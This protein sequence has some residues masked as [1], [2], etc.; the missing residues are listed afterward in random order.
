MPSDNCTG[1]FDIFDHN[2]KSVVGPENIN[3][4]QKLTMKDRY[5]TYYEIK[6]TFGIS[7]TSINKILYGHL[8]V[9][10]TFFRWIPHNLTKAQK[11]AR[12]D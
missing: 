9:K 6:A 5:V 4:V 2:P 11:D 7:S 8:A 3:A 1:K 12:V 10:K